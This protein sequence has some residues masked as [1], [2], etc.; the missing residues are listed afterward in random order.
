MT[1]RKGAAV[2]VLV[3]LV[4]GS[5][6]PARAAD[7]PDMAIVA[8]AASA[9]DQALHWLRTTQKPDGSYGGHLGVTALVVTALA[10]SPRAYREE[11]GPFMR[12]AVASIRRA[13]RPDGAFAQPGGYEMY[14]TALSVIALKAL[15]DARHDEALRKAQAWMKQ[16]QTV[17]AQGYQPG[18]KFY[19]GFGYGSSL[20][21]DLSNTQYAIEALRASGLAP[22]DPVFA[23]AL[24]FIQ[25]IQNRTESN[26]EPGALDDG[27]FAYYPGFSFAP[28]GGWTSTGSMSYAGIKSFL[29]LELQPG[30]P[31]VQAAI[32]WATKHY[33]VDENPGMGATGWYYYVDVFSRAWAMARTGTVI[34][35]DGSRRDWFLDLAT[36]LLAEQ[37]PEG[38]WVNARAPR[39]WEDR[40]ELATAHAVLA[41]T[42]G[43][44]ARTARK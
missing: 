38:Y 11:D 42:Y 40:P 15:G 43:I 18:D 1:F 19:G 33:T 31:R 22:N 21:P 37:R 4:S 23:K 10:K 17:E 9:V 8:K 34:L 7:A 12:D 25:R 20:R 30:D 39:F 24:T 16:Q 13:Q 26:A 41:L 3:L 27:G 29:F 35:A 14:T 6:M 36:R 44:Q 32:R 28:A 5:V 2:T